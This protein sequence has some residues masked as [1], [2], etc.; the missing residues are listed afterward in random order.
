MCG[1]RAYESCCPR[2]LSRRSFSEG[3][4]RGPI[5]Q[6]PYSRATERTRGPRDLSAVVA[7]AGG[8]RGSISL[9]R[10]RSGTARG[11][12]IVREELGG[13]LQSGVRPTF[14]NSATNG[15][16]A[17]RRHASALDSMFNMCSTVFRPI[18]SGHRMYG[19]ELSKYFTWNSTLYGIDEL[20]D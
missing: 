10:R 7:D 19:F 20:R 4:R 5:P 16:G 3:G 17:I 8:R 6:F 13:I 9:A 1:T 2:D 11:C 18:I 15:S 12:A 14:R